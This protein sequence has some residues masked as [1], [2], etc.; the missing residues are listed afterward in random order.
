MDE[1]ALT[2]ALLERRLRGAGLDV[3]GREPL[4]PDSPL[5]EL[6]NV[7]ITPHVSGMSERFWER[8]TELVIENIRRYLA[9]RTLVNRVDKQRG[10]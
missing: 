2:D 8:E 7:L 4:D 5:W 9:G 3:F 10:Y 1:S 6:E